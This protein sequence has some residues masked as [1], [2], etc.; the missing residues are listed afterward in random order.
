[1]N[2]NVTRYLGSTMSEFFFRK[3]E[4]GILDSNLR[5]WPTNPLFSPKNSKV[6]QEFGQSP[7]SLKHFGILCAKKGDWSAKRGDSNQ[8]FHQKPKMQ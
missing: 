7:N 6:R 5:A 4:F 1:M 8:E 2:D 3:K